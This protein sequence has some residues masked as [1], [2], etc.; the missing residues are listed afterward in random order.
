MSEKVERALNT[1]K[2]EAGDGIETRVEVVD[3]IV[4]FFV[5][6]E[7]MLKVLLFLRDNPDSAFDMLTDVTAVDWLPFP[8]KGHRFEIVYHLCSTTHNHRAR[9]KVR[10]A[11]ESVKT[12]SAT[13]VYPGAEWLE[14]EVYDMFGLR[15][16][17]HP[18]LRRILMWEGF[19]GYPLRKDYPTR[20]LHPP[21]RTPYL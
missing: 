1:L 11:D 6:P 10:V 8:D 16:S 21:E 9:M 3:G 13:Q 7:Q 20:G 17:G 2:S 14:R 12:P 4:T 19:E 15:F 18:D 5:L